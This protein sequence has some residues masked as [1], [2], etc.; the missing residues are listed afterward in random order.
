MPGTKYLVGTCLLLFM[1]ALFPVPVACAEKTTAL[2]PQVLLRAYWQKTLAHDKHRPLLLDVH[3]GND[4]A[5]RVVLQNLEGENI[6]KSYEELGLTKDMNDAQKQNLTM[7]TQAQPV[8]TIS[9]GSAGKNLTELISFRLEAADHQ[10]LPVAVRA[11]AESATTT[12][13][14][15]V[16]DNSIDLFFGIDPAALERLPAGNYSIRATVANAGGDHAWQGQAT[17]NDVNVDLQD[18]LPDS[19]LVERE[20]EYGRF[21]LCDHDFKMAGQCADWLIGRDSQ[22]ISGWELRGDAFFGEGKLAEAKDAY[23]KGLELYRKNAKAQ[24]ANDVV[25]PPDYL[26]RRLHEVIAAIE[27]RT[28]SN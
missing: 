24:A 27:K 13:G 5:Y 17:S 3:L 10:S 7:R 21:Y 15:L 16:G 26:G 18:S 8:P 12:G 19:S 4:E 25:E 23:E 11:L 2:A 28:K 22:S 20:Y 1:A 6:R 9:V 14:D